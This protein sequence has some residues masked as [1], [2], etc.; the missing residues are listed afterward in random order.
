M[1]SKA[2]DS[3]ALSNIMY[4][5]YILLNHQQK[6]ETATSQQSLKITNVKLRR[7]IGNFCSFSAG[8][9]LGK[10]ITYNNVCELCDIH[11]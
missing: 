3:T 5:L 10:I 1:H 6:I 8:K 11:T 2:S 7:Q 4:I 9:K